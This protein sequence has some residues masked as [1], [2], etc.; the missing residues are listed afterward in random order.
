MRLKAMQAKLDSRTYDK[1]GPGVLVRDV[2]GRNSKFV[3]L[4]NINI[5]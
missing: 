4:S 5:R 1:N 2:V 3:L